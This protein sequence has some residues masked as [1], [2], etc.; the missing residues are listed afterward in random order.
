VKNDFLKLVSNPAVSTKK[1][2]P[3]DLKLSHFGEL[4]LVVEAIG[5]TSIALM[6]YRKTE[7]GNSAE[8]H[9]PF[10]NLKL[11]LRENPVHAKV[12]CLNWAERLLHCSLKKKAYRKLESLKK[13]IYKYDR[14][15]IKNKSLS[16]EIIG[17]DA[18]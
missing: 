18:V 13:E 8:L 7:E 6:Y 16:H 1:H 5:P 15:F 2:A 11:P 4:R 9:T 10:G 17:D 14:G 3:H 12:V